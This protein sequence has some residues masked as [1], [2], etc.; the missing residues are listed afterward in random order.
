MRCGSDIC[1]KY[2]ES[3]WQYSS[4]ATCCK[5]RKLSI[6]TWADRASARNKT[7]CNMLQIFGTRGTI[8]AATPMFTSGRNEAL[9]S[10]KMSMNE[11]TSYHN[12]SLIIWAC[13]QTSDLMSIEINKIK[14]IPFGP[15][16]SPHAPVSNTF[17]LDSSLNVRDHPQ[18]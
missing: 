9:K 6:K 5:R 11:I 4:S 15:K 7:S 13:Q 12:R 3:E 10:I 8:P 16:Y 2:L 1:Y 18:S 17:R 14:F